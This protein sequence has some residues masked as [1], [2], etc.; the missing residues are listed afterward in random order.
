M[1]FN[2]F[3]GISREHGDINVKIL[4]IASFKKK[5]RKIFLN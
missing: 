1:M 2:D 5:N 4:R 3:T